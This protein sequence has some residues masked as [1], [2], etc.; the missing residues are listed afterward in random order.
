MVKSRG[1]V[2]TA[3]VPVQASRDSLPVF[4]DHYFASN[5]QLALLESEEEGISSPRKNVPDLNGYE[6]T[7]MPMW[8]NHRSFKL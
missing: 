8:N 5:G 2:G 3:T 1:Y 4:S 7:Y 6:I